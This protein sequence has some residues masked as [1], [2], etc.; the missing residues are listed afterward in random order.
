MEG[1]MGDEG[2]KETEEERQQGLRRGAA[3]SKRMLANT[4]RFLEGLSDSDPESRRYV[5]ELENR[6]ENEIRHAEARRS[7]REDRQG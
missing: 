4:K 7:D 1:A 3:D 6:L 5:S 2:D